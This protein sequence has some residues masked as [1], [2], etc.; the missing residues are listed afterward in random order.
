VIATDYLIHEDFMKHFYT[1][2]D[3]FPKAAL[4]IKAAAFKYEE[5]KNHYADPLDVCI[6][7]LPLEYNSNN[8]APASLIKEVLPIAL[9]DLNAEGI[10]TVIIA[11]SAYFKAATKQSKAEP[12]YGYKMPCTVPG[13]EHM[14]VFL[15]AN[16]Q[17]LFYNPRIQEKL[18]ISLGAINDH[19]GGSYQQMGQDIIHSALYVDDLVEIELVLNLL[20]TYPTL[21]CDVETFG[22]S[23]GVSRIGTIGFAWDEHSGVV[24]NV[25]HKIFRPPAEANKL[26]ALL[27][28]YFI[29]S[30]ST[31][32]Y[33]NATFDIRCII[34]DFFMN[35][36]PDDFVAMV[37]ALDV[38][39]TNIHDTK[40]IT[41]LATNNTAENKLSLKENA[42]PFAGNYAKDDIKDINL[43]PTEELT[44]YNLVDCLSTWYVFNRYYDT[45]VNDA[46]L[47]IYNNIFI[48][49]LKNIT[50][51]E[52]TGMPMDMPTIENV[53]KDLDLIMDHST[54]RLLKE[55]LVKDYLWLEQ[56]KAFIL[57]NTLLKKKFKPLDDFVATLN[58]NSP[59]Q[60]GSLL[61]D[62]L[63]LPI[64]DTTDTGLP[65]TGKKT[66]KKL[67]TY[68]IMKFDIQEDEL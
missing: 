67:Y 61:Y 54:G 26:S 43:I 22:L 57:K 10:T 32:I 65:A 18:D 17:G 31:H 29:S 60:L 4:L 40:L 37:D 8:K 41:Y 9:A 39:C 30:N 19:L 3:S 47:D 1:D 53:S 55:E 49:S 48:P 27:R 51:M 38:M 28:D 2:P 13:Y 59:K 58:P 36:V 42:F 11:D 7:V 33:H 68:L 25:S 16:Y 35:K 50:Q 21:T 62:F 34:Y 45:M 5:V 63:G 52:L 15:T 14:D 66:I 6:K 56:K 46:Q 20:K 23:I 44:E 64:L 12:H 24:I